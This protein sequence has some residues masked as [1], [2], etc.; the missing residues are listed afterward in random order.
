M[1]TAAFTESFHCSYVGADAH[2]D[3]YVKTPHHTNSL[4]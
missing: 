1:C 3:P 2:I 4:T